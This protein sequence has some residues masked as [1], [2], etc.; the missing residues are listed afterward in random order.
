MVDNGST[1]G[2]AA[3]LAD[4]S[5]SAAFPLIILTEPK[6]GVS[7][8]KNRGIA[9]SS[10]EI[11]A[12]TD[13]D[14]RLGEDYFAC[15]DAAYG[16]IEGPALVGGRV[17]LGDPEDLPFTIKPDLAPQVYDATI[18]PG[19]FAHGCNLS[20]TRSAMD[21]IGGFDTRLGPGAP[22]GAAEDTDIVVRAYA[23]GVPA[24]Y[25]PRFA[26]WHH[27]GR[28]DLDEIRDL[29]RGYNIGNGAIYV[30]HGLRNLELLRH[31]YW[32]LRGG[33]SRTV[34]RTS[35]QRRTRPDP[36]GQGEG[37]SDRRLENAARRPRPG[38]SRI[39]PY[40]TMPLARS[41]AIRNI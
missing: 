39:P 31:V 15:L 36:L 41:A 7:R 18:H 17:E 4:W 22:L 20:L 16:Q 24:R 2:T 14:C 3:L 6:A 37:Q 29:H 25:D 35:I 33:S 1:D 13:D 19:G 26:V 28:R 5:A 8:A 40:P 21:I 27:H 12:F 34:R 11:L 32:D 23:A 10:G 30:K 38:L 9:A